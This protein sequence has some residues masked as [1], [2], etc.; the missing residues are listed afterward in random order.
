MMLVMSSQGPDKLSRLYV[1]VP[2]GGLRE[3]AWQHEAD[4]GLCTGSVCGS[5]VRR[6]SSAGFAAKE[7]DLSGSEFVVL[8]IRGVERCATSRPATCH[9]APWESKAIQGEPRAPPCLRCCGDIPPGVRST[10]WLCEREL[11]HRRY[12]NAQ[13]KHRRLAGEGTTPHPSMTSD[14]ISSI[15]ITHTVYAEPNAGLLL[16]QKVRIVPCQSSH[17]CQFRQ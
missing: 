9:G 16:Q 12:A 11:R 3:S 6:R 5:R 17:C 1:C 7:A 10:L 13:R 4:P 2:C 15:T 14:S 8:R